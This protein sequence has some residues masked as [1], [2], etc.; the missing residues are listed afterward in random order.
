MGC[1][2]CSF[3]LCYANQHH[4]QHANQHYIAKKKVS[5]ILHPRLDKIELYRAHTPHTHCAIYRSAFVVTAKCV[6]LALLTTFTSPCYAHEQKAQSQCIEWA[7]SIGV[8]T[9]ANKKVLFMT[10][11]DHIPRFETH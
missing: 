9:K 7:L 4:N 5:W 6:P 11:V 10:L 3:N 2:Y 8:V 1:E